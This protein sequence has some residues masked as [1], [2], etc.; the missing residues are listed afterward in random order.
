MYR[1]FL[2]GVALM[3]AGWAFGVDYS[4]MTFVTTDGST[5]SINSNDLEITFES[6][7]LVAKNVDSSLTLP[8]ASI[9]EFYFTD[10][11]SSIENMTVDSQAEI[12]VF[13]LTGICLG[14]YSTMEAARQSLPAGIYL[15]KNNNQT[16]SKE[17]V[18]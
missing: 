14:K 17:I 9:S 1:P 10:K 8:L 15:F 11:Q 18:K 4:A 7:N 16:Y 6:N 3:T 5:T 2:V 13:G 12:E